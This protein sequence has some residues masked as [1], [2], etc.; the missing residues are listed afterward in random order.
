MSIVRI[1]SEP[2][3]KRNYDSITLKYHFVLT[4]DAEM[5]MRRYGE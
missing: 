5:R 3:E 1:D 4:M 2:P